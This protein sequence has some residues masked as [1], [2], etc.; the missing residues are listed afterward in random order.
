LILFFFSWRGEHWQRKW[1][2]HEAR[3]RE[4]V[5]EVALDH[6]DGWMSVTEDRMHEAEALVEQLLRQLVQALR[7]VH[8]R[9][10][11]RHDLSA[12]LHTHKRKER[13]RES[14]DL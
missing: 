4:G 8:V 12:A 13:E 5:P 7:R 6:G 2:R 10:Q 14:E 1:H 9:Q 11:P 3:K